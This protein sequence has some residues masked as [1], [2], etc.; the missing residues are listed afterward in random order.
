MALKQEWLVRYRYRLDD[1]KRD[2]S[3][4]RAGVREA[5]SRWARPQA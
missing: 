3:E 2:L 1:W 5:P 4:L